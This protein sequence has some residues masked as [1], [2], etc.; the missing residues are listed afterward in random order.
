[1]KNL[2]LTILTLTSFIIVSCDTNKGD[3]LTD[4]E[5]ATIKS[6]V[7]SV[8]EKIV[9]NSE[10]GNLEKATDPYADDPDF[11]CI[12]NGAISDYNGFIQSN[13]EFFDALD[14]Q[15]FNESAMKFTFIDNKTVILTYGG[16]ALANFK[17]KQKVKIDPF[18]ATLVFRKMDDSWKVTYSHESGVFTPI[19]EDSTMTE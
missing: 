9:E 2:I 19:V 10:A 1:M 15:T 3:V 16:S 14:H 7:H 13:K 4:Q 11:I 12:S 17:D 6:E 8:F 18:A 5:K